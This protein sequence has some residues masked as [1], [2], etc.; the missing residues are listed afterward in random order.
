MQKISHQRSKIDRVCLFTMCHRE[1]HSGDSGFI[2]ILS[3]LKYLCNQYSAISFLPSRH[4]LLTAPVPSSIQISMFEVTGWSVEAVPVQDN[5]TASS[6][7]RKR[8]YQVSE[9][10]MDKKLKSI[11]R[12]NEGARNSS[13]KNKREAKKRVRSKSS[14]GNGM[15]SN[16]SRSK[17]LKPRISVDGELVRPAKKTKKHELVDQSTITSTC[18]S[19]LTAMQR[20]MKQ[21][22]DGARFRSVNCPL[23]AMRKESYDF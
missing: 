21:S 10:N 17:L 20:G 3:V 13:K 9:V 8:N 19:K 14:S 6:K 23:H 7:K 1:A 11:A 12:D 18:T 4:S 5:D 15:A 22:L 16:I 2:P